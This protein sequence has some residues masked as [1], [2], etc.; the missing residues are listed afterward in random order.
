[1]RTNEDSTMTFS[2]DDYTVTGLNKPKTED[3]TR[4]APPL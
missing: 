4:F 2:Y 3:A 1:M